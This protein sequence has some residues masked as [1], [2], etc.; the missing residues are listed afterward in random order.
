MEG[1]KMPFLN[2]ENAYFKKP[3][4]RILPLRQKQAWIYSLREGAQGK[5]NHC[6]VC[7]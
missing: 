6:D 7:A 4:A 2:Y 5:Q 3:H 1:I